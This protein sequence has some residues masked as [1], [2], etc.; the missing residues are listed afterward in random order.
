MTGPTGKVLTEAGEILESWR[1]Y[2][3][4]LYHQDNV[5]SPDDFP[6]E[7]AEMEPVPSRSEVASVL[8]S[9]ST[10]K[11]VWSNEVPIKPLQDSGENSRM[12][13]NG[14][15]VS[16]DRML[17]NGGILSKGRMLSNGGLKSE[18]SN[19]VE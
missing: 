12:L 7:S 4:N 1:V 9:L 18:W 13:S 15:L 3:D 19:A 8:I 2:S 10:G 6:P 11:A 16:N 5:L 17:S 14:G